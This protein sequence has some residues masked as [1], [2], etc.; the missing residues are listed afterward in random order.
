[1][2]CYS[3]T[4]YSSARPD[5]YYNN[6]SSKYR[7]VNRGNALLN[8]GPFLLITLCA[9]FW[10]AATLSFVEFI[11]LMRPLFSFYFITCIIIQCGVVYVWNNFIQGKFALPQNFNQEPF[12]FMSLGKKFPKVTISR[13]FLHGIFFFFSIIILFELLI[14]GSLDPTL[15]LNFIWII[16]FI[17]AAFIIIRGVLH[18]IDIISKTAGKIGELM[19]KYTWV[20]KKEEQRVHYW[21]FI[22]SPTGILFPGVVLFPILFIIEKVYE[23]P[24]FFRNYPVAFKYFTMTW[25]FLGIGCIIYLLGVIIYYAILCPHFIWHVVA[26]TDNSQSRN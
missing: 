11:A 10:P 18:A 20:H 5:R 4:V 15:G 16:V 13:I 7:W 2:M 3:V 23:A 1:M 21:E 8:I 14:M 12:L 9:V 24:T 17:S 6:V 25:I 19:D 22:N 26:L